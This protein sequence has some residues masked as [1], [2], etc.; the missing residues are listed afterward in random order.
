MLGKYTD[1]FTM[2]N[3]IQWAVKTVVQ[4]ANAITLIIDDKDIADSTLRLSIV[5]CKL[6]TV[7]GILCIVVYIH[8]VNKFCHDI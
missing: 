4:R 1:M 6:S 7:M 3:A 8:I 2:V 5:T